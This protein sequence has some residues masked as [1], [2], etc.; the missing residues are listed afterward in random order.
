MTSGIFRISGMLRSMVDFSFM[1]Q[2]TEPS[3][4]AATCSVLYVALER[5]KMQIFWEMTSRVISA[6]SAYLLDSGYVYGVS[7]R[8]L[9]S[10]FLRSSLPSPMSMR[11]RS[12]LSTVIWPVFAGYVAPRAVL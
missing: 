7:L 4:T 5:L 6:F 11:P 8:V 1:R 10:S 9:G 2:S 12:S 3:L